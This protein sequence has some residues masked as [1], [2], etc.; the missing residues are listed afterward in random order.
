M[1]VI[2]HALTRPWSV[3]KRFR[4]NPEPRP[5]WLEEVCAE[6]NGHIVISNEDYFLSAEGLLMPSK[7]NQP[8]PDLRYFGQARK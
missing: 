7:K 6:N 2:D 8:A 4:R 5:M 3:V 1:T